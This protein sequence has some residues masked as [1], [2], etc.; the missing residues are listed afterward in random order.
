MWNRTKVHNA[1]LLVCDGAIVLAAKHQSIYSVEGA[2]IGQD[3]LCR[4]AARY[5]GAPETLEWVDY[6]DLD[7]KTLEK[8]IAVAKKLPKLMGPKVER[9][10]VGALPK[11]VKESAVK[12]LKR[13]VVSRPGPREAERGRQL[14]R[15][16]CAEHHFFVEEM[17]GKALMVEG[18]NEK[19][20]K[21]AC[22]F[23]H[24]VFEPYVHARLPTEVKK[25]NS[26]FSMYMRDLL[27]DAV[28]A[29]LLEADEKN[30]TS[31]VVRDPSEQEAPSAE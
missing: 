17:A 19:G 26:E 12:T 2:E 27:V 9:E 31:E 6:A 24:N 10:P 8:A 1:L 25:R 28:T 11:V 20:E 30:R 29:R 5:L 3:D 14:L 23:R 18:H 7:I 4:Y 16:V 15:E 21:C 13:P 22:V